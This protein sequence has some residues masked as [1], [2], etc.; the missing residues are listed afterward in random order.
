MQRD[1]VETG[2]ET[3]PRTNTL[4]NRSPFVGGYLASREQVQ[5]LVSACPFT[6]HRPAFIL[7]WYL[8]IG[9]F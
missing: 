7:C 4:L 2:S 3:Q 9:Q 6:F 8:K 1:K 5:E